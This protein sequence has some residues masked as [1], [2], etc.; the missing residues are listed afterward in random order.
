M[1]DMKGEWSILGLNCYL[2]NQH[3]LFLWNIIPLMILGESGFCPDKCVGLYQ[4]L[5][6]STLIPLY[7][8]ASRKYFVM[9]LFCDKLLNIQQLLK[10]L[11]K[12][13][14]IPTKTITPSPSK[15]QPQHSRNSR[16]TK[17]RLVVFLLFGR[18][19]KCIDA[20]PGERPGSCGTHTILWSPIAQQCFVYGFQ[21]NFGDQILG[22][23]YLSYGRL[24]ILFLII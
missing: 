3:Q 19:V 8:A 11:P 14:T 23:V 20:I 2:T 13:C 15:W 16:L 6:A 7:Y 9:Q 4:G 22:M 18:H 21:T 17:K 10:Y 1:V 24:R 12:S 5:T